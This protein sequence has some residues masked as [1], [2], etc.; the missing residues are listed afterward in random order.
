MI[1]SIEDILYDGLGTFENKTY[2]IELYLNTILEK[3][4]L[5]LK[6]LQSSPLDKIKEYIET[7]NNLMQFH[8]FYLRNKTYPINYIFMNDNLNE[9]M[10]EYVLKN[11]FKLTYENENK[12]ITY[13]LLEN[14]NVE[15]KIKIF[16]YLKF[17][18]YD[19]LIEDV[20]KYNILHY[21]ANCDSSNNELYELIFS[22]CNDIN[23]QNNF[24]STPLLLATNNNNVEYINF[25][26]SKKCNINIV[27]QNDNSSL[28]YACM[29]N[30]YEIVETLITNGANIN[31]IDKQLDS[32]FCYACGCDNFGVLNL[33]IIKYLHANNADIN[34]IS[35]EKFTA[36]H[37]ASGCITK[38]PNLDVIK[39]LL[40][41][42]VN[43]NIIDK[44][45]NTFLD[46]LLDYEDNKDK[47]YDIIKSATLS[48]NVKNTLIIRFAKKEIDISTLNL[49]DNKN[50][51]LCE[52]TCNICHD[53]VDNKIIKCINNHC[54]DNDCIL[55]WFIESNNRVCPLCY[56]IIDLSKIY[57][58]K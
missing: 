26:I 9:E 21:L 12:L 3:Y 49:I 18:D 4:I 10:I 6:V 39:Y 25:L 42:N 1:E 5:F 57:F 44:N 11:K 17:K 14:K 8:N 43:P 53:N 2:D 31:A 24:G 41:I 56:D 27:N 34:N 55:N 51:N 28:M 37:Y 38:K 45:N 40:T 19:F 33:K 36:L 23:K 52:H 35:E 22:Y 47:I 13:F 15:D 54:F 50:E 32:A 48:I 16:K 29:Y 30:N 20:Y 7:Y 58:I 46:Y